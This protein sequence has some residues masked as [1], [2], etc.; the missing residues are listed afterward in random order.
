MT[1]RAGGGGARGGAGGLRSPM[2]GRGGGRG[3]GVRYRDGLVN[4]RSK[5]GVKL[6][7]MEATVTTATVAGGRR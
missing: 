1:A 3:A 6:Y 5:E 4:T 2:Y 7:K